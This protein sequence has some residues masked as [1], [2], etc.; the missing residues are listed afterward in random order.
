[1]MQ[2]QDYASLDSVRSQFQQLENKE[3]LVNFLA[4]EYDSISNNEGETIRAYK[5]AGTCM[6][7]EYVF[8]SIS[9]LKYFNKGKKV[10]EEIIETDKQV[11]NIYLRLMIQLNIPKFLNYYKD[12]E[13]DLTFLS[14]NMADAP[15]EATY[16]IRMIETLESV[17]KETEQKDILQLI[18]VQ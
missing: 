3:D 8:S 4:I 14:M 15:I 6:M 7:A 12:I 10:L 9:K 11:E 18:K 5:A 16:K 2:A 13:S 17:A 1:M